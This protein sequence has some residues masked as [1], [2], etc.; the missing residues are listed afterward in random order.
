MLRIC[1][2]LDGFFLFA[3]AISIFKILSE[4]MSSYRRRCIHPAERFFL[5]FGSNCITLESLFTSHHCVSLILYLS[6]QN[7]TLPWEVLSPMKQKRLWNIFCWAKKTV[8]LFLSPVLKCFA[9]SLWKQ[10]E[11]GWNV[12]LGNVISW[13]S[14]CLV[15]C[16]D[17]FP[18][19]EVAKEIL[20]QMSSFLLL[21]LGLWSFHL[22][23]SSKLGQTT[24]KILMNDLCS[25]CLPQ[26]HTIAFWVLGNQIVF[27]VGCSV[28][29]SCDCSLLLFCCF[30]GFCWFL[31]KSAHVGE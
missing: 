1:W 11:R 21:L 4:H 5:D 26:S 30:C 28:P 22:S 23:Y 12:I 7:W 29:W 13:I 24:K 6:S 20:K 10:P 16:L 25:C 19:E 27:T 14:L 9:L 18:N 8:L 17:C 15:R 3:K 31:A 2:T